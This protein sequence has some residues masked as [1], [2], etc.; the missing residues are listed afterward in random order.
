MYCMFVWAVIMGSVSS[1]TSTPASSPSPPHTHTL[2]HHH[3]LHHHC[4]QQQRC[5]HS[6]ARMRCCPNGSTEVVFQWDTQVVFRRVW[7]GMFELHNKPHR[8][9][10][11]G[12]TWWLTGLECRPKKGLR[13]DIFVLG[14][15]VYVTSW[16]KYLGKVFVGHNST[17]IASRANLLLL[18]LLFATERIIVTDSR[19]QFRF[20]PFC[21]SVVS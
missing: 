8:T 4:R 21:V 12:N 16:T 17:I 9:W 5:P 14:I 6:A 11:R 2:H 1:K 20:V 15:S 3:H 19:K 18:L 7:S 10:M 13:A